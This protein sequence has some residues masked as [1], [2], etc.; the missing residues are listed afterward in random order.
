MDKDSHQK[1]IEM[2]SGLILI[3]ITKDDPHFILTRQSKINHFVFGIVVGNLTCQALTG[4]KDKG[5]GEVDYY[6]MV[7]VGAG[8]NDFTIAEAV[9]DFDDKLLAQL[10]SVRSK[11]NNIGLLIHQVAAGDGRALFSR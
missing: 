7:P 5:S 8:V 6:R 2:M 10:M 1:P 3:V 4:L 9:L 11:R